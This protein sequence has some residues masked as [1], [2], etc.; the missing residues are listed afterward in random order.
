M[1]EVKKICSQLHRRTEFTSRLFGSLLYTVSHWGLDWHPS[2]VYFR[3]RFR[4][5]VVFVCW[6]DLGDWKSESGK[7]HSS[8]FLTISQRKLAFLQI[9]M[10]M[11]GNNRE[12]FCENNK[13]QTLSVA[14][15]GKHKHQLLLIEGNM[16]VCAQCPFKSR[17]IVF[18]CW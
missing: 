6:V 5:V 15:S 3:N 13:K 18:F 17:R 2:C 9:V 14:D 4:K 11:C 10:L 16:P 7:S 1:R 12:V 8:L